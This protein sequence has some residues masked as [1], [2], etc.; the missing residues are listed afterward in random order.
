MRIK[1]PKKHLIIPA[2]GL[3]S[4]FKEKGYTIPKPMLPVNDR[5]MVAQVIRDCEAAF[6]DFDSVVMAVSGEIADNH[7]KDLLDC[8][9]DH[10]L[11]LHRFDKPTRGAAET[12]LLLLNLADHIEPDDIV[13]F[14]NSDQHFTLKE[15]IEPEPGMC[16]IFPNDGQNKWSFA[17]IYPD[18]NG[19]CCIDKIVE[20]PDVVDFC[21]FPTVGVYITTK[22]LAC[23]SIA[24]DIQ[25]DRRSGP[26]KE[27]Y[28]AP[29]LLLTKPIMVDKFVPL[30]TPADYE[31]ALEQRQQ[32]GWL[33]NKPSV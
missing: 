19:V 30:G 20:K 32:H 14:A 8:L 2:A 21:D 9:W 6:G 1:K 15:K 24:M 11:Y 12:C 26:N 31:A 4:R 23:L 33:E 10:R 7:S 18:Q 22:S 25:N 13:V 17:S 5:P 29:S 27:F 3:G 28:L 16:L